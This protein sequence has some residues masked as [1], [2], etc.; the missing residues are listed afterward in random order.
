MSLENH[1]TLVF[2][3]T[4]ILGVDHT[5]SKVPKKSVTSAVESV[6]DLIKIAFC[7]FVPLLK[8]PTV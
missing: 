1:P 8:T 4:R 2:T 5:D 3:L 7:C 6:S